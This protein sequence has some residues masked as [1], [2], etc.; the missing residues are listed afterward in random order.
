[1][2]FGIMGIIVIVAILAS[3]Y[4]ARSYGFE[5]EIQALLALFVAAVTFV[6][7]HL[8]VQS[9][10]KVAE[11]S[12]LK[13]QFLNIISHQLLT[14]LS[15]MKWAINLL[16]ADAEKTKV[17]DKEKKEFLYIISKTNEDMINTV[18][19]LLDIS[20]IDIGKIKLNFEKVDPK[21]L[22]QSIV[23]EKFQD[24]KQKGNFLKLEI[25]DDLPPILTDKLKIKTILVNLIDN[26]IKYSRPKTEIIIS[27]K[28]NKDKVMFA[29]ED[30]GVGIS[31]DQKKHIYKKFFRADNIFR[32]QTQGFGLGLFVAKFLVDALGGELKFKSKENKGSRF[33]FYLPVFKNKN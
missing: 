23:G 10:S 24:A 4:F 32:Y 15:S 18:N 20:R 13:S 11:V 7:G 29:V 1:M 28:K 31:K 6:I 19:F 22:I 2:L 5:P 12:L 9:F 21:D 25:G 14:P 16:T 26:A 8:V 33:W 27:V 3:Y 17:S 30:F